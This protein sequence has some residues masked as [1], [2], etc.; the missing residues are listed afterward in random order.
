MAGISV[1]GRIVR[2]T[3][4]IGRGARLNR[5]RHLVDPTLPRR[6]TGAFDCDPRSRRGLDPTGRRRRRGERGNRP[7]QIGRAQAP[8][9][10]TL[11][12][13]PS[14]VAPAR[15][16]QRDARPGKFA[17]YESGKGCPNRDDPHRPA[18]SRRQC[19]HQPHLRLDGATN[20]PTRS[21]RAR[22][23]YTTRSESR[24]RFARFPA[25]DRR[26]SAAD[27]TR[28]SANTR[29]L[30]FRRS[31]GPPAKITRRTPPQLRGRP[32]ASSA[33]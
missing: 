30:L 25:P 3:R 16:S 28:T 10:I 24:R 12:A 18:G 11:L 27:V 31:R 19:N 20:L 8:A 2:R 26:T 32:R 4:R 13:K 21:D 9:S 1:S 14:T 7:R 33:T 15:S 17:T 22:C 29:P 5:S 23:S 6:G